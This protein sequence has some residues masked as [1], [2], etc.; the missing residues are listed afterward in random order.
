MLWYLLELDCDWM[1]RVQAAVDC[2]SWQ[3][4]TDHVWSPSQVCAISLTAS[5][6]LP[7]NK[8]LNCLCG[9]VCLGVCRGARMWV[10]Y[11]SR[12]IWAAVHPQDPLTKRCVMLCSD[13][14]DVAMQENLCV[15]YSASCNGEWTWNRREGNVL[16]NIPF[17]TSV[18]LVIGQA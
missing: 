5:P 3:V 13:C 2:S 4:V 16:E 12:Q 1:T 10:Y 15:I 9:C 6:G 7:W 11:I 17:S 14:Q 8:T 18:L